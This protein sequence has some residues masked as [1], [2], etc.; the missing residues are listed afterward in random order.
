M[1][2][3]NVDRNVSFADYTRLQLQ[4]GE[5]LVTEIFH[6]IQG[7]GPFAGHPALFIR[8]AGCNIGAKQDC[9]WCDTR[10][11][12]DEGNRATWA[13]V[14]QHIQEAR[15]VSGRRLIVVTGGEPLLQWHSLTYC[16]LG[17]DLTHIWQFE[18]NGLLLDETVL[19]DGLHA[20]FVVSPK[21]P[22]NRSSYRPIP[23]IWEQYH[24]RI[25][26]KYVVSADPNSPYHQLPEQVTNGDT[27]RIGIYVSGMTAYKLAPPADHPAS[28]WGPYIDHEETAR[29]YHY[30]AHL[31]QEHGF[32]LSLQTHLFTGIK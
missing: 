11:N 13:V 5:L 9:P 2:P 7:E 30:A 12:F 21:I 16:M 28:I 27:G 25:F 18:T 1:I 4:S 17:H 6:T 22:H 19:K 8:L 10:F 14:S 3:I 24:R 32:K 20:A 23:P 29:N 31:A 15:T 26:L